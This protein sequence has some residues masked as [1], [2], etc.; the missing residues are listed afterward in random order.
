MNFQ[1][2]SQN[3][4]IMSIVRSIYSFLTFCVKMENYTNTIHKKLAKHCQC[5]KFRLIYINNHLNVSTQIA[6]PQINMLN[7]TF[8]THEH[9]WHNS[10]A[11]RNFQWLY[12]HDKNQKTALSCRHKNC[13]DLRPSS[14]NSI[15]INF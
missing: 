12:T 13:Y 4:L 3:C 6:F 9:R 10:R 1:I 14:Q 11:V 2:N 7:Q 15:F 8:L 5:T